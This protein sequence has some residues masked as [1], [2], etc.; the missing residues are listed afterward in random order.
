MLVSNTGKRVAGLILAGTLLTVMAGEASARTAR[1]YYNHGRNG[2]AYGPS[3]R[4]YG[5]GY[6]APVAAG[7]A[8]LGVLG[9]AAG[10]AAAAWAR[11]LDTEYL[12]V[13]KELG[14]GAVHANGGDT[15]KQA[16]LDSRLLL[17]VERAFLGL[18]SLAYEEPLSRARNLSALKSAAAS[19][20]SSVA[21]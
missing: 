16:A 17:G 13:M 3:H 19:A 15:S 4:H 7:A 5:Y 18:L 6:A 20:R 9:L 10:A 14:N 11:D 2:Y 8:A 1:Q 12:R 21:G